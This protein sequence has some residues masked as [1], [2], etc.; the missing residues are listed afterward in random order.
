M[1]VQVNGDTTVEPNET[2]NVNL[3]GATGNATITDAQGVGTIVNDDP[4]WFGPTGRP[5]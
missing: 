5:V 4:S 1:T 2:F 3:S